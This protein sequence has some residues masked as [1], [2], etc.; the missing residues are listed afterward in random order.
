MS[1]KEAPAHLLKRVCR[2]PGMLPTISQSHP[3]WQRRKQ[4]CVYDLLIPSNNE[5]QTDW[6]INRCSSRKCLSW[7]DFVP[8]G[9][10]YVPLLVVTHTPH[11]KHKRLLVVFQTENWHTFQ[12]LY[13]LSKGTKACKQASLPLNLPTAKVTP[14]FRAE[15][16]EY[17]VQEWN[18]T[19]LVMALFSS[20]SCNI[21]MLK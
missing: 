11:I 8:A 1:L 6:K 3:S 10:L 13:G 21:H 17:I 18:F 12:P 14:C 20:S 4:R 15:P 5:L 2:A 7:L 19:I 9:G 16:G